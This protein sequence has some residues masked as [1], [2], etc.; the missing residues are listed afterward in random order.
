MSKS[1]KPEPQ[2]V[3][4]HPVGTGA[5][6]KEIHLLLFNAI[7]H[8]AAG[9]I[10]LLVQ[11]GRFESSRLDLITPSILGQVGHDKAR[12]IAFGQNLGF[13][14]HPSCFSPA[15]ESRVFKFRETPTGNFCFCLLNPGFEALKIHLE[16]LPEPL[17]TCQAKTVEHTVVFAP[18]HDRITGKTAIGAHDD[19]NLAAKPLA[20]GQHDLLEC[21]NRA[22]AGIPLAISQLGKERNVTAKAV[23]RQVA[24]GTI[25]AVK[26]GA[27]LAAMERIVGRIQIQHDLGTLAWNGLDSTLD[28]QLFD[29]VRLRLDLMVTSVDGLCAQLQTIERRLSGERFAL[30]AL[31]DP[32]PSEWIPLAGDQPMD[33]IK[34]QMVMII[35]IFVAQDQ[36]MNPLTDKL[37]NAVFD[38]TRVTVVDETVRKS[39]QQTAVALQFAKY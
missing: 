29:L 22:L 11:C 16:L 33:G 25:I 19:P 38:I 5:I 37:L 17:V 8:V 27:L 34:P 6:G 30:I 31:Q 9:A 39:S 12:I 21:F 35:E 36:P 24:V 14:N 7:L 18:G 4:S 32:I 2:L 1:R 20:N 13:S 3:G 26:I 23:E 15:V 10:K 28:E